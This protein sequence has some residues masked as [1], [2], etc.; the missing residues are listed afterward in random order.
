V[1]AC[2]PEN[3]AGIEHDRSS[4]DENWNA[5]DRPA[6]RRYNGSMS[7]KKL[8]AA[9]WAACKRVVSAWPKPGL[10]SLLKEL[11]ELNDDNRRFLHGRL[12]VEQSAANRNDARRQIAKLINPTGVFNNRFRHSD[13]KRVIDNYAKATGDDAGVAELLVADLSDT[14]GTFSEVGDYEPLVD[15]AYASMERLHR[16]LERLGASEAAPVVI[17]LQKLAE[18]WSGEFGYGLSDEL[19]DLATE[20]EDRLVPRDTL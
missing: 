2:A 3:G 18:R 14:L 13:V 8:S 6:Q 9:S 20:W 7:E 1:R 5:V 16:T 19:E 10:L 4:R 12:L 17:A 11:Y 15:H